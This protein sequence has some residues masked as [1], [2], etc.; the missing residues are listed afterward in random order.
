MEEKSFGVMVVAL[1]GY[2]HRLAC[3]LNRLPSDEEFDE[4]AED[5]QDVI[6][7]LDN[8]IQYAIH[9]MKE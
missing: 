3:V 7:G 5:L 2:K 1:E 6:D 9:F 4:S 8:A